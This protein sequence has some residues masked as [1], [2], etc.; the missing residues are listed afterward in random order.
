MNRRDH[1]ASCSAVVS[2]LW[3]SK[4]VS[5][6]NNDE[7]P[8]RGRFLVRS[9]SR[10][11]SDNSCSCS[12]DCPQGI[13]SSRKRRSSRRSSLLVETKTC[14]ERGKQIGSSS[15]DRC[16]DT[17]QLLLA[18]WTIAETMEYRYVCFNKNNIFLCEWC[19]WICFAI[20]AICPNSYRRQQ[21]IQTDEW[22][23]PSAHVQLDYVDSDRL[24]RQ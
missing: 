14:R 9:S 20:Q 23:E 4:Q 3:R 12:I 17:E 16:Q 18:R 13:L 8:K 10:N 6:L 7:L 19:W 2:R 24:G 1:L 22:H 11:S 15:L 21:R 5:A